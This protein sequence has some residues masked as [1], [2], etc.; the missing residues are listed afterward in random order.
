MTHDLLTAAKAYCETCDIKLA[1]LARYATGH[2]YTV[3][4]RLE[5]GGNIEPQT[6]ERIWAYMADNPAKVPT[7]RRTKAN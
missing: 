7:R 3:F 5:A 6:V 2:N 1:T 4:A